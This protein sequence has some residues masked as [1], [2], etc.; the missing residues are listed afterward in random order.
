MRILTD[1]VPILTCFFG[2]ELPERSLASSLGPFSESVNVFVCMGLTER[3][4]QSPWVLAF[5][6][7]DDSV[8]VGSRFVV[9][10]APDI[11]GFG[12]TLLVNQYARAAE[13]GLQTERNHIFLKIDTAFSNLTQPRRPPSL[14]VS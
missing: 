9:L 12:K 7:Q 6:K 1:Q 3:A 14:Q 4:A 13:A 11:C 2:L 10:D 5:A 8:C